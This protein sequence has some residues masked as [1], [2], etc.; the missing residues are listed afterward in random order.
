[1]KFNSRF[2]LLGGVLV[3]A[4]G[5]LTWSWSVQSQNVS[6][7]ELASMGV[8]ILPEPISMDHL[9]L[10]SENGERFGRSDLQGKWTFGFFGYTHCPDICPV[11]L[12]Q[13]KTI[14]DQLKEQGDHQ[15][16]ENVQ[17]LFVSVDAKRDR[18]EV[19][20]SYTD[21]IDPDIIGV[22]GTPDAIKQFAE[23]VYVGFK[24]L[25]DPANDE[26]YLVDHQGHIVIFDRQGNCYGFI[27]SPFEDHLLARI[28]KGLAQLS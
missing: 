5:L 20:K 25:G 14:F 3:V 19:V 17:R 26:D 16:L 2:L 7:E 15:T 21:S 18:Y 12:A 11:T 24:Q 8:V 23:S 10:V 22:T 13:M 27:K 6:E 4:L 9:D 1:M 28:F